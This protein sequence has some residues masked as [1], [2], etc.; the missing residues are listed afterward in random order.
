LLEPEIGLPNF[1]GRNRLGLQNRSKQAKR[2]V[3]M[4]KPCSIVDLETIKVIIVVKPIWWQP[5]AWCICTMMP[6]ICRRLTGER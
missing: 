5:S 4:N 1:L 3:K 2:G 6:G